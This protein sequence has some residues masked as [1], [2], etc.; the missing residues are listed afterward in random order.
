MKPH[1]APIECR[2]Y[3]LTELVFTANPAFDAAKPM[4]LD[5]SNLV[6]ES[7]IESPVEGAEQWGIRLS[8]QQTV[9]PDKNIPYGFTVKLWGAFAPAKSLPASSRRQVLFTTGSSILYGVARE[10]VR[11]VTSRGPFATLM[12]PTMSFYPLS[13]SKPEITTESTT[14]AAETK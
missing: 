9:M 5:A 4:L 2:S 7:D 13:E 6:I 3:F 12:L 10:I 1:A 14:P 11:D 8:V